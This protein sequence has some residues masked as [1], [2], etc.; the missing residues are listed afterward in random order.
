[1][2]SKELRSI[3]FAVIITAVITFAISFLI[4]KYIPETNQN[5]KINEYKKEL[6]ISTLCQYSCPLSLQKVGN[7]TEYLP[8]QA[9]V[10]SCTD[11]F[12]N[13]PSLSEDISNNQI[14]NDGLLSDMSNGI[15]D[16]KSTAVD[17]KSE[18]LNNTLFFSCSIEKLNA[19]KNKYNYLN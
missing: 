5:L 14:K 18:T 19:L 3:I 13:N 10:K 2:A 7:K 17:V 1:M 12:K 16:C 8:E 9:C 15:I 6:Y 4:L 11:K